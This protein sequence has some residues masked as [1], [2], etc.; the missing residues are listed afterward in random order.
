MVDEYGISKSITMEQPA[1]LESFERT[2]LPHL[3]AAFNLARWLTRNQ[4]DAEDIVQESYLRAYRFFDGFKGGDGKG[5]LLAV[6]RNTFLTWAKSEKGDKQMV[7]FDEAVHDGGQEEP[8]AETRLVR[9]A[10]VGSLR[11]CVEALHSEYREVLVM[12]ELED[13]SYREISEAAAI[14]LGTVMSRLSRARKLLANC[15]RVR[16]QGASK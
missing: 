4:Q 5:W 10:G 15:V 6:V 2:M 8:N 7:A 3:N 14:P 12:R 11:E 16:A 9:N 13:M 1:K